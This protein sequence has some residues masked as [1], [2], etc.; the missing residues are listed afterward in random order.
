MQASLEELTLLALEH[1]PEAVLIADH[2]GQVIFR[3][4]AAR[5]LLADGL[6]V[7]QSIRTEHGAL[8]NWPQE[9]SNLDISAGSASYHNVTICTRNGASAVVDVEL[10]VL[11]R[12]IEADN[13]SAVLVAVTNNSTRGLLDRQR[14]GADRLTNENGDVARLIHELAN[15]LDGAMRYMDM[16]QANLSTEEAEN[17][18]GL[19]NS[20]GQIAGIVSHYKGDAQPKHSISELIGEAINAFTLRAEAQAVAIK[21]TPDTSEP[22]VADFRLFQVFCNVIKNSLDAM[23]TDG[24][25]VEISH[26]RQGDQMVIEFADSG[27]GLIEGEPE[28]IFQPFYTTKPPETGTG[29]GLTVCRELLEPLGGAITAANG[30]DAGLLVTITLPITGGER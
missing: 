3:S 23:D 21:Y 20:L 7:M 8:I 15:P 4:A 10:T 11:C 2:D 24:G 18:T 17:L 14:A 27:P 28:K 13:A 29:L 16:A 22:L 26:A 30:T 12:D 19:R 6:D 5:T 1:L 9:I 25:Q